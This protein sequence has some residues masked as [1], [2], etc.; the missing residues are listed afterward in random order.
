[1]DWQLSYQLIGGS[2]IVP[3]GGAS[4]NVAVGINFPSINPLTWSVYAS[5]QAAG[6]MGGGVYGGFGDGINIS[7]GDA[8]TT[9]FSQSNYAEADAGWGVSGGIN[10][11]WDNCGKTTGLQGGLGLKWGVGY[12]GGGF[13][14]TSWSATAASPT[15]GSMLGL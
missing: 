6:G 9:G 11:G 12:G 14:G 8:P 2:V 13:I 5:G 1:L 7:H 4:A 15:L 3:G 10:A